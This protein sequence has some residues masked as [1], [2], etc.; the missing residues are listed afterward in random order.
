MNNEHLKLARTDSSVLRPPNGSK[1]VV[2]TMLRLQALGV[3]VALTGCA[4]SRSGPIYES[5]LEVQV[6]MSDFTIAVVDQRA[7]DSIASIV[8]PR[9]SNRRDDNIVAAALPQNVEEIATEVLE[10]HRVPGTDSLVFRV[11]VIKADQEFR[12]RRWYEVELIDWEILLEL[13]DDE[14]RVTASSVG[15]CEAERK[16]LDASVKRFQKMFEA[17]FRKSISDALSRIQFSDDPIAR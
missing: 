9:V 10:S 3:L 6:P 1:R 17:C 7:P 2:K 11:Q 12:S 4:F 14:G 8:V 15:T 16:S 5:A 13:I